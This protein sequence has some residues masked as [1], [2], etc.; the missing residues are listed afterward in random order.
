MMVKQRPVHFFAIGIVFLLLSTATAAFVPSRASAA[1]GSM[2]IRSHLCTAGLDGASATLDE[3]AAKCQIPGANLAITISVK[4]QKPQGYTFDGKGEV[5]FSDV[6]AGPFEVTE[7]PPDGETVRVFCA[8]LQEA[9]IPPDTGG[10]TP[11]ADDGSPIAVEENAADI[12]SDSI[13]VIYRYDEYHHPLAQPMADGAHWECDFYNVAAAKTG[14]STISIAKHNCPAEAEAYGS[15]HKTLAEECTEGGTDGIGFTLS[16]GAKL[17]VS[18]YTSNGSVSF[19]NLP[20]GAQL[21]VT[22]AFPKGYD[23]ATVSCDVKTSSGNE[24][25]YKEVDA[26]DGT[27]N[28]TAKDGYDVYCDWYDFPAATVTVSITKFDCP[29]GT[30][31]TKATESRQSDAPACTRHADV[32][33]T[34]DDSA[35]STGSKQMATDA[36]GYLTFSSLPAGDFELAESLPKG[37]GTPYVQCRIGFVKDQPANQPLRVDYTTDGDPAI[38]FSVEPGQEADCLWFNI[39]GSPVTA[40]PTPTPRVGGDGNGNGN[41]GQSNG[42]PTPTPIATPAA[43]RVTSITIVVRTCAPGYDLFAKGADPA[44]DCLATAVGADF[45]SLGDLSGI[46][47]KKQ[48]GA[49][50]SVVFG[51]LSSGAHL[52]AQTLPTGATA[53]ILDCTST[54]GAVKSPLSPL[55]QLGTAGKVRITVLPGEQVTCRWFDVPAK[56]ASATPEAIGDVAILPRD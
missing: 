6:T 14:G 10:A 5:D 13:R 15:D 36:Q 25:G 49:D 18:K 50:G 35:L 28:F 33:F 52:I 23:S 40:T 42:Y 4:D 27:I 20:N 31:P 12:N 2:A 53:F 8:V 19:A 16:D 1:G 48:T 41:G 26:I 7:T 30:D 54:L 34:L 38:V 21:T 37:Y 55:S 43:A 47:T 44:K 32:L 22:E 46:L 11:V 29:E 39:K 45:S 56:T 51:H 17:E 24:S 9:S 3:L